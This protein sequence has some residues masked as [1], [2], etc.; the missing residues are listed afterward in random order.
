MVTILQLAPIVVS[1]PNI[2]L[3]AV[4]RNVKRLTD[5]KVPLDLFLCRGCGHLQL[6]HVV[7]PEIQYRN[8]L[9][10]TSI[11]SG[12]PAHFRDM[13]GEIIG[14]AALS[15]NSRIVEIGSND[16][17][18]LKAFREKGMRVLGIDPAEKIA[19]EASR[20]GVPTLPDFFNCA[21]GEKV[22][23]EYGQADVIVANNTF[24]NLDD[25]EDVMAGVASLLAP[26]GLLVIET[27]Y[28]RD[29]V[30][31]MLI[32]TIY[33]EH[34]SYFMVGSLQSFFEHHA[35]QLLDVQRIW[36]KGG[37]LRCFVQRQNATRKVMESVAKLAQA[38]TDDGF[39][40]PA[41][42]TAFREKVEAVSERVKTAI[43]AAKAKGQ[44]I[45]GYGA[46][47]GS[48]TSIAQFN[49]AEDLAFIVDDNPMGE[50]VNIAG[51]LIPVF[52]S[53][54]IYEVP[55]SLVVVFA[56]RYMDQIRERHRQFTGEGRQFLV[57]LPDVEII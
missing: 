48:M 36:T 41:F 38:E 53:E 27:Q 18:L 26:D 47:V 42:Y 57:P 13:A 44:A 16:G 1:T 45:I 43:T 49:L 46:S 10:V 25:L 23:S 11:S 21:V 20:A 5:V 2:D 31:N 56:W 9:Y 4:Q 3:D 22:A 39:R 33:H 17:T 40:L 14:T 8:F 52:D 6:L 50:R 28:G 55:D 15:Q 24:A 37:S 35:M 51:R 30:D 29:V 34:L 7:D 12:L 19:A 32:D 54:K